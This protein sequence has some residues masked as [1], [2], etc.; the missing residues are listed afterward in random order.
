[1]D[2]FREE[3]YSKNIDITLWKKMAEFFKPHY[4][5]VIG[6][7]AFMIFLAGLDAFFPLATKFALDNFIEKRDLTNVPAFIT[8]YVVAIIA[9]TFILYGFISLG[10]KLETSIAYDI[11][12]AGFKKLQE[13]SFSYYDKTPVG[14]IM[15][16]M[17]SDAQRIGDVVAWS[18][19]DI[20]WAIAIIVIVI[21]SMMILNFKLSLILIGILPILCV[22]SFYFQ[23]KI[24]KNQRDVRKINSKITGAITEG[25]MGARTTKTLIREE[26]N[27][28]EYSVLTSDMRTVSVRAAVLSSVYLP[29]V[30]S[31]S[32][33]GVGL[34]LWRGGGAVFTGAISFGTLSVFVSYTMQIFEP[35]QQIARIFSEMQSAQASAE[36]TFSLVEKTPD[37]T[38]NEEVLKEFAN[39][40]NWPEIVGDIE[41]DNV[42]FSYKEG[43]KV[44]ESFNLHVKAGEKTAI[45]GATGAGKSTIVNLLCRFYEPTE[46]V[47]KIDGVDYKKRPQIWLQS[48]LGYVLQTPHLF[49]GTIMENIRY[50]KLTATDEEVIE[51]AKTVNAYDFIMRKE[52]GFQTDVGE[53]GDKLSA[54]EKQLVSFARAIIANPRLFILDEATSSIDTETEMVIQKAV[55]KVLSGRTSFIIAHRLST[56]RTCDRILVLEHGNI[57]ESGNHKELMALKG[58]YYKLYTNQFKQEE[59]DKVLRI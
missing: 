13:L 22:V 27:L 53:G 5:I 47:I 14:W 43:E 3:E 56:I 25:I 18:I 50:G 11:R 51:T 35:V 10:A 29:V 46:G 44:L 4:K 33:L 31:I 20:F 21:I 49:S 12:K 52:K 19:V 55:D 45:V 16:R 9:Q 40:D 28:K 1:M 8:V 42:G 23:R 48:N 26:E 59:E 34:I 41:F 30:L 32:S 54:G 58:H 15:A 37:I 24:L 39:K 57:I 7:G 38:D 17:T 6:I 2:E 36:R